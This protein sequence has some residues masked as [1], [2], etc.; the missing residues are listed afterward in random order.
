M[1]LREV[2]YT[3]TILAGSMHFVLGSL[4]VQQINDI[5][6][7]STERFQNA[8]DDASQIN[9]VDGTLDYNVSTKCRLS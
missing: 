6:N 8:N 2:L 9:A 7:D 5:L 1:H 3:A 4:D